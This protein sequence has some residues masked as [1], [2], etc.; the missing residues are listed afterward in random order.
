MYESLLA[1]SGV[2]YGFLSSDEQE[3]RFLW[4]C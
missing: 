1:E 2:G 3:G 4:Q